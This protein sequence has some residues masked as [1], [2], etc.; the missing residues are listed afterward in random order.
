[1]TMINVHAS[2]IITKS[3]S[4]HEFLLRY[5]KSAKVV[6]GF[7]EGKDDP[8]F[9]RGFIESLLPEDWRVELWPAGNK[10]QVYKIYRTID[11]RRF[12]KSR[13]CFFVDRDLSDMIPEP[14]TQ[15]K[16]IYATT[17]YSIENDI[18]NKTTCHRI[19]S[20]LCGFSNVDH[21][22]LEAV[23]ELFDQEL[24]TFLQETLPIMSWIIRWRRIG[25]RPNLNNIL[26]D[27]LFSITNGRLKSNATPKGKLNA[28]VYLH[29]QCDIVCDH[30]INILSIQNEFSRSGA[31]KKLTRGKYIFWFLIEFCKSVH[32]DALNLFKGISKVP[33]MHLN[34]SFSNGMALI[35]PRSRIPE[36]LRE[37]LTVTYCAYIKSIPENKTKETKDLSSHS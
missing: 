36:S 18:V 15:D 10:D 31:Y 28:T 17:G 29:D 19:L 12:R 34:L 16:N 8:C 37:F 14:L 24:E 23:C 20:E 3:A 4:Y 1:M 11:W 35:G 5:S 13:V 32:R 25:E 7:V 30:K 6:Y 21:Y 27:D 2:A 33:K 9:Y 22:D 26:M